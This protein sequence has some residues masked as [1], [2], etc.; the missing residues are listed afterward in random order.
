MSYGFFEVG[1]NGSFHNVDVFWVGY[2]L[3][4]FYK[5]SNYGFT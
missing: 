2:K 3:S 4:K 1:V 5:R